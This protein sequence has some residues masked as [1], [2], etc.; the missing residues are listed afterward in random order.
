MNRGCLDAGLLV[1]LIFFSY[2]FARMRLFDEMKD[3]ISM[4]RDVFAYA[5]QLRPNWIYN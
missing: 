2:V 5:N 3:R 1:K 4:A